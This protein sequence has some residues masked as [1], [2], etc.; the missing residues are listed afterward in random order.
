MYEVKAK[1]HKADSVV[2]PITPTP[3][4]PPG[5]VLNSPAGYMAADK[6]PGGR[7]LLLSDVFVWLKESKQVPHSEVMRLFC[8]AMPAKIMHGLYWVQPGEYAKPVPAD[9]C[10][11]YQTAAQIVQDDAAAKSRAIQ[12]ARKNN[13]RSWDGFRPGLCLPSV[14]YV[15]SKATPTEPGLPALRRALSSWWV[16]HSNG[17]YTYPGAFRG[18]V[19]MHLQCLAVSF[20]N[21]AEI[22][23]YEF[24]ASQIQPKTHEEWT[25]ERLQAEQGLLKVSG[26]KNFTQQLA[27]KSGL[28]SREVTRRIKAFNDSNT[29]T[30][31]HIGRQ[32]SSVFA[33][34]DA[35]KRSQRRSA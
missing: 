23:G 8:D 11:G 32:V 16:P 6:T 17:T 25:G 35:A 9:F 20:G 26:I 21:A 5:W 7:L 33:L 3:E 24:G 19:N 27:Q 15:K 22:W 14:G 12:A 2:T 29:T 30:A 4:P 34:G 28:N 18:I 13:E 10:F 31:A 1:R